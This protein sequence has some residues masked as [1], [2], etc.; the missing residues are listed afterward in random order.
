MCV[1]TIVHTFIFLFACAYVCVHIC[2]FTAAPDM[3]TNVIIDLATVNIDDNVSFTLSWNEPFANFD[4][5][6]NYTATINC[7]DN[8][9]CPVIVDTD[10]ATRTADVNFIT[11]LSMMTT[12]SVTATNT[13]GTSDPAIRIITGMYIRT[14]INMYICIGVQ[15]FNFCACI[16]YSCIHTYVCISIYVHT[17][18]ICM[19]GLVIVLKLCC[20]N[21]WLK[22]YLLNFLL[23]SYTYCKFT[24]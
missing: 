23:Q 8:A 7:T 5:I 6:V 17:Y 22:Q 20:L 1:C 13:I 14:I 12:L 11:D 2:I 16:Q 18:Y 21:A 19:T 10:N 4:P 3:I 15:I 9:T 24:V